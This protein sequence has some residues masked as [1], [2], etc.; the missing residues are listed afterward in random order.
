[1]QKK[2]IKLLLSLVITFEIFG[3][4]TAHK[5]DAVSAYYNEATQDYAYCNASDCPKPTHFTI[6]NSDDTPPIYAVPQPVA[7]PIVRKETIIVNFRFNRST[8]TKQDVRLIDKKIKS[9]GYSSNIQ[10]LI[11]GFTDNVEGR[12]SKHHANEIL[13]NK[14]A[15]AVKKLLVRKYGVAANKITVRGKPLCCYVA[16]NKNKGGRKKNRRAQINIEV[17]SN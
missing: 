9:L 2:F 3:C 16:T 6:D 4:S 8:L 13:A 15:L 10:I 14:R 17:K 11:I 5:V 7:K 1:M 12:V